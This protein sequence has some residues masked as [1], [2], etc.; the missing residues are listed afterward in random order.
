M[1][2]RSDTSIEA[3]G[4]ERPATGPAKAAAGAT[5]RRRP[6]FLPT[7]L[8]SLACF[9]VLFEFLAFQLRAG[10]DPALGGAA[11]AASAAPRPAARAVVID[12]K[13]V[14]TRVVQLPPRPTAPASATT[15]TVAAPS[16]APAVAPAAPVAPAP[17]AAA[18]APAPAAPAPVTSSS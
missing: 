10:N 18:P 8:A 5:A 12:R 6:R 11:I 13:L 1:T 4:V 16:S 15:G 7:V 2:D 3:A 14:K 9:V 17:V